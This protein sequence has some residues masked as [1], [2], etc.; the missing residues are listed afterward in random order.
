MRNAPAKNGKREETHTC[1]LS[2]F[3]RVALL[4]RVSPARAWY[5]W[6]EKSMPHPMMLLSFLRHDMSDADGEEGV[7]SLYVSVCAG[8]AERVLLHECSRLACDEL[9]SYIV[10]GTMSSLHDAMVWKE[11][12][13]VIRIFPFR[14]SLSQCFLLRVWRPAGKPY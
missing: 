9:R 8:P 2:L 12:S 11:G 5:Q 6:H 1:S 10:Y 4:I 14:W 13:L 7:F 3:L